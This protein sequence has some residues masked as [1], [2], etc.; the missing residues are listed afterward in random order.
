[1]QTV[2]DTDHCIPQRRHFFFLTSEETH[3]IQSRTAALK[4]TRMNV[5]S[6]VEIRSSFTDDGSLLDTVMEMYDS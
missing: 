4:A 2:P 3:K 6:T 5:H 1:M